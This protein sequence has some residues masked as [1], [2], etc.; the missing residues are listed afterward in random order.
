MEDNKILAGTALLNVYWNT[1]KKD[2]LDLI[3]PFINYCTAQIVTPRSELCEGNRI[4]LRQVTLRVRERF[5]YADIPEVI[6]EK[7]YKRDQKHYR[8]EKGNYYLVA[9]FDNLVEEMN[10]KQIE[11]AERVNVLGES[12]LQYLKTHCQKEKI[13]TK[14]QAIEKLQSF[15]V[16]YGINITA[17]RLDFRTLTP[18]SKEVYYWIGQYIYEEKANVSQKYEYLCQLINGY[19]LQTAIYMQPETDIKQKRAFQKVSFYYDTPFLV[20]LLGLQSDEVHQA[21]VELHQMLQNQG[22]QAYYFPQMMEE[23]RGI[24]YA[25]QCSIGENHS[26]DG[27]TLLFLDAKRFTPNDVHVLIQRLPGRL[28]NEYHVHS[29]DLPQFP[30]KADGTVDEQYVMDEEKARAFVAEHTPHYT[31]KNLDNDIK[32][33]VAIH[34]LRGRLG[35]SRIEDC[36]HI[37][38]TNNHDLTQAFNRYY[39]KNVSSEAYGPIIDTKR[40]AAL[41]WV[42]SG[43]A[44]TKMAERDLL[45]NA[46]MA[47]QPIPEMKERFLEEIEKLVSMGRI[48]RDEA[49]IIRADQVLE[50]ELNEKMGF[51]PA[52]VNEQSTYK[53]VKEAGE[54]VTAE[55][56]AKERTE[57]A[58]KQTQRQNELQQRVY[59]Q[60]QKAGQEAKQKFIKR[61]TLGAKVLAVCLLCIGIGGCVVSFFS[62]PIGIGSLIWSVFSALGVWDTI[63]SKKSWIQGKIEKAGNKKEKET[64]DLEYKKIMEVIE[65]QQKQE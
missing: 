22:G 7:I 13:Y 9:S 31:D 12:L 27:R 34:K 30:Q 28:E 10:K 59:E 64:F 18:A 37:L 54:R 38:V 41:V 8:K 45:Q 1:R 11:C 6:V 44:D 48:T 4:N 19:Y 60:A 36:G 43:I 3:A 53:V 20:D 21:A 63:I 49:L 51:D 25:Y 61:Y 2:L 39:K 65:T 17:D 32:S 24:L 33:A 57:A 26:N 14:E 40:L 5:G 23:L 42:R 29:A 50:R 52:N 35:Y 62:G 56:V 58:Q 46:Y 15:F 47:M 55:A 16:Y